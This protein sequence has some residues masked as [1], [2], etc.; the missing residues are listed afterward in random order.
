MRIFTGKFMFIICLLA[1][2]AVQQ[3]TAQELK[4]DT[5]K[6]IED[7]LK[8]EVKVQSETGS[9]K[10]EKAQDDK[11]KISRKKLPKVKKEGADSLKAAE[12]L[13]GQ[14]HGFGKDKGD[15]SGK[16]FG[17]QRAEEAKKK[18][19]QELKGAEVKVKDKE[20][21]LPESGKKV[22]NPAKGAEKKAEALEGNIKVK[23][24]AL[25]ESGEKV[26]GSEKKVK[27]E[28]EELEAEVKEQNA[29]LP[30]SGVKADDSKKELEKK[31]QATEIDKPELQGEE[32]E[33][34]EAG[35]ELE[36]A[37]EA[38]QKEKEKLEKAN[39]LKK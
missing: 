38:G 14:G 26:K 18:N 10:L 16:E 3:V 25:P 27:K 37:D 12:G 29:V 6:K 22:K 31:V 19:E 23:E 13:P 21:A 30:E 11:S 9:K 33:T 17:K 36:K 15:L 4:A 2:F 20:A 5:T 24:P 8:K 35:K 34:V 39:P 32:E 7:E 1:F 28:S